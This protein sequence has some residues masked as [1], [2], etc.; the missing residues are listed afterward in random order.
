[1]SLLRSCL[2]RKVV[3]KILFGLRM[4]SFQ[5]LLGARIHEVTQEPKWSH[6][7]TTYNVSNR[8]SHLGLSLLIRSIFLWRDPALSCFSLSL[9]SMM[10]SNSWNQTNLSA[11]YRAVNDLAYFF[12]LCATIG[13]LMLLVT[14]IYK[15]VLFLFVVM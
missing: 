15:T 10:L 8:S 5:N 9:A 11:W 13:L 7:L 12:V 2:P 3:L 4:F 1:V 6:A 14:P